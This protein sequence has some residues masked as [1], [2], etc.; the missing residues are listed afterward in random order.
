MLAIALLGTTFVGSISFS[1]SI[2]CRETCGAMSRCD[3]VATWL[4]VESGK[5]LRGEDGALWGTSCDPCIY[6][7]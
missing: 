2:D 4:A 7:S 3:M 6:M 1:C 5:S